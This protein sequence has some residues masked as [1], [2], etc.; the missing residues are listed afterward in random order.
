MDLA[1]RFPAWIIEIM[2][3]PTS[4]ERF[5]WFVV[6]IYP[7]F[8]RPVGRY[9]SPALGSL[10]ERVASDPSQSEGVNTSLPHG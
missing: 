10:A 1:S 2:S 8:L 6:R 5:D 7:C 4:S 3:L 9:L